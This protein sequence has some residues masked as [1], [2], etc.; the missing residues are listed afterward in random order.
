M[1]GYENLAQMDTGTNAESRLHQPEAV[2]PRR[3]GEF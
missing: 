2:K 1:M 3:C